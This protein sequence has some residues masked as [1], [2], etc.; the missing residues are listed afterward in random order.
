MICSLSIAFKDVLLISPLVF[1]HYY[2]IIFDLLPIPHYYF[3]IHSF[4]SDAKILE[5][6]NFYS[7]QIYIDYNIKILNN[8]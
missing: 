8:Q 6:S 5:F 2:V 1:I 7:P 3:T 4:S